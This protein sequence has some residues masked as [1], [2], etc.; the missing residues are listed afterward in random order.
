MDIDGVNRREVDVLYVIHLRRY[1]RVQVVIY[2]IVGGVLERESIHHSFLSPR[3]ADLVRLI[4]LMTIPLGRGVP[5]LSFSLV[6]SPP[7]PQPLTLKRVCDNIIRIIRVSP[8]FQ[9]KLRSLPSFPFPFPL[10][11]SLSL[12]STSPS[13]RSPDLLVGLVLVAFS[14]LL[15]FSHCRPVPRPQL[16][17]LIA[18]PARLSTSI[19]TPGSHPFLTI[20][21]ISVR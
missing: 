21:H 4:P 11:L 6:L 8:L 12:F 3:L 20:S 16:A 9:L 14:S 17:G 1:K 10:S 7:T 15:F 13:F 18:Q 5:D 19:H 2:I